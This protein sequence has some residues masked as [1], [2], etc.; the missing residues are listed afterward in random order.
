MGDLGLCAPLA[1]TVQHNLDKRQAL[2]SRQMALLAAAAS[3]TVG[4]NRVTQ[5]FVNLVCS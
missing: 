2:I 4:F 5:A 1:C 3:V